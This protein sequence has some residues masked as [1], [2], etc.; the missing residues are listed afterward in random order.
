MKTI[1]A[2]SPDGLRHVTIAVLAEEGPFSVARGVDFS[3]GMNGAVRRV[4][5]V[6]HTKIGCAFPGDWT[7]LEA[8]TEAMRLYA[9][10]EANWDRPFAEISVDKAL[11]RRFQEVYTSIRSSDL[12]NLM[13]IEEDE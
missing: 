3:P 1:R 2:N 5:V 12:G 7:T 9:K 4:W 8:A 10:I 11:R 13:A 6:Y